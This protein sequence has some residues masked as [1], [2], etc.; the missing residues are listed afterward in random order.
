MLVYI[1]SFLL[2]NTVELIIKGQQTLVNKMRLY[3]LV[4][5]NIFNYC[6]FALFSEFELM[7]MNTESVFC[8]CD[9]IMHIHI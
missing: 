9:D 7:L 5:F 1:K 8:E 2:I 3:T 6:R 4:L